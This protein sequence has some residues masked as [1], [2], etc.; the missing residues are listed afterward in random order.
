MSLEN[1]VISYVGVEKD[2]NLAVSVYTNIPGTV[3]LAI[4]NY[5][6]NEDMTVDILAEDARD[7]AKDLRRFANFV[8]SQVPKIELPKP[9]PFDTKTPAYTIN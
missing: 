1:K 3:T 6:T 9:P 5:E 2:D 7:L 8:E 4:V